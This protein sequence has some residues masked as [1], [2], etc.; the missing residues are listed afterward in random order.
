MR[1]QRVA[2]LG[3]DIFTPFPPMQR[4]STTKKRAVAKGFAH[5]HYEQKVAVIHWTT[6]TNRAVSPAHKSLASDALTEAEEADRPLSP[7]GG[8]GSKLQRRVRGEGT[9][10]R[11]VRDSLCVH[12]LHQK[13]L[14]RHGHSQKTRREPEENQKNRRGHDRIQHMENKGKHLVGPFVTDDTRPVIN[15]GDAHE[16]RRKYVTRTQSL[17]R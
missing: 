6:V 9:R 1:K 3:V 15:P 17:R 13:R 2:L 10:W 11:V 14:W 8:R 4:K 5:Q 16:R 12:E 7:R